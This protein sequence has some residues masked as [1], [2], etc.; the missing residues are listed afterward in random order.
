M[1]EGLQRQRVL[2]F[3]N[4]LY[5]GDIEGAL[6]RCTDDIESL[7]NAPIDLL[8]HMGHRRGKAQVRETWNTVL[9][10]YSEV[11][12]EVPILVVE[13]DQVAANIRVYFRRNTNQRMVQFN[14]AHFYTLRGGLISNIRQVL[15]T[16]DLIQQLHERDIGALLAGKQPDEA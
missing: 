5:S 14:S 2:D 13:G 12:C 8:P 7:A 10:R 4:V 1:T 15:D 9:A 11:R 16:F 6:A 3:I